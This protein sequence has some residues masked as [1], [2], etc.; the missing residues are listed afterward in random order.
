MKKATNILL[1]MFVACSLP[2]LFYC[3][4]SDIAGGAGTGNPGKT[5]FA[6]VAKD[7]VTAHQLLKSVNTKEIVIPD[8]LRNF[9]HVDSFYVI[10]RRIH[11]IY[12]PE[13]KQRIDE[14]KVLPPLRKDPSSI[15]LEGPFIFN[16]ITG[17][18]DSLFGTVML[19]EANYTAVRLVI[20][21]KPEKN[22]IFLGG[23][24]RY[25]GE[26][27]AF[28]FDLSLNVSV[29]YENDKGVYVSGSDSTEMKV[30]LDASKWFANISI[31]DCINSQNSPFDS[32]GVFVLNGKINDGICAEIPRKINDNIVNS[33]KL[34]INQVKLK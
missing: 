16:A 15:V 13:D 5:T 7:T 27:H 29:T 4:G 19:P 18:P 9:F 1:N 3:S 12:S 6:I 17:I 25:L 21:N 14:L 10:L 20:E 28:K 8:S 11:F 22:S 24:F 31:E 34:R 26:L 33:G 30:E 2:L 32:N 23:T